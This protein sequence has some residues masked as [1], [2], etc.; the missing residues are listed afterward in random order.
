MMDQVRETIGDDCMNRL[1]LKEKRPGLQSLVLPN[2]EVI[3]M[4]VGINWSGKFL[5]CFLLRLE[6][7]SMKVT[8]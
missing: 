5:E 1:K 8:R 7:R 2:P 4:A 6:L 3:N